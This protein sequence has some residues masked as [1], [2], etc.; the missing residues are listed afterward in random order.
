MSVQPPILPCQW[1]EL[2]LKVLCII[3]PYIYLLSN[4]YFSPNDCPP[5]MIA[6][7]V[8]E[9]FKFLQPETNNFY[10][11]KYSYALC[12]SFLW[13]LVLF[14]I[15]FMDSSETLIQDVKISENKHSKHKFVKTNF[16]F[17]LRIRVWFDFVIVFDRSTPLIFKSSF[18]T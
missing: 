3:Y 10:L 11:L 14:R 17:L 15:L 13:G 4:F 1:M 2:T 5:V 16:H 8:F 12:A 18:I 9:I 6:L 7:F